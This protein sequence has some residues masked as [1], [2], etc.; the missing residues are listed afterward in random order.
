MTLRQSQFF[1]PVP[2]AIA[3]ELGLLAGLDLE[4]TRTTGSAEQRRAL[5]SGEVDLVV[6]A[7]DNLFAWS[8]DIGDLRLL[9]Q[10]E[11]TTPLVIFAD[12]G[13]ESIDDL[14][15]R[16]FAVDALT[17]GFALVARHVLRARQVEVQYVEAGGVA[18]RLQALLSG[19]VD[20]T[21]LGPPFDAM[22]ADAGKRL[23]MRIGDVLPDLPGQGL[24]A[25]EGL[26]GS[27][28]LA[29]YLGALT[30]AVAEGAAMTD[31]DGVALLERSGFG[32]AA[33]TAWHAR[34]RTLDVDRAGLELLTEIRRGL[35][36]L[37]PGVELAAL[38][39]R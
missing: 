7:I 11:A 5:A 21:L 26:L 36:L 12:A 34:P 38:Q 4:V 1:E 27:P 22:A 9:A 29:A 16:R 17:N 25:R 32:A 24:V 6:T 14:Q 18:E 3:R 23:L 8:S 31:D 28:E 33:P 19:D 15:G 13:V 10:L 39:N 37:P 30:R 35:G 2:V 20:A